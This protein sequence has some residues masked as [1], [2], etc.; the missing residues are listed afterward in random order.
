MSDI[1]ETDEWMAQ[2]DEELVN[3]YAGK[4]VAVTSEGVAASA[5]S[6]KALVK[7][8]IVQPN[9]MIITRIPTLKELDTIW[10]L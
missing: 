3:Q 7:Q 6:F 8:K 9:K 1:Y 5:D 10:I 4:W 2:H